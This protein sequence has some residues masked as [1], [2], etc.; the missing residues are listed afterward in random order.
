M[1]LAACVDPPCDESTAAQVDLPALGV[2]IGSWR[3]VAEVADDATERGRG[4]RH[5]RCGRELLAL[6]P[7]EPEAPAAPLP[8]FGCALTSS[9]DVAF[10]RDERVVAIGALDPCPEPCTVCP[11]V[12]EDLPVHMVFEAPSGTFAG[13]VDDAV[14]W[15]GDPWSADEARSGSRAADAALHPHATQPAR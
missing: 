12:G 13:R 8:V 7:A 11:L 4:W 14:S 3:A 6:L 10:V 15:D 9:L 2:A 1:A 5:R